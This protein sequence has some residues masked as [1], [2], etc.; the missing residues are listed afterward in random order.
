MT[1][2]LPSDFDAE[3][4]RATYLDVALSGL[5]AEEHYRRFGRRLGRR[6]NGGPTEHAFG[7]QVSAA[8][9]DE[10][11]TSDIAPTAEVMAQQPFPII[12]R[13]AGFEMP[14]PST[15]PVRTPSAGSERERFSF[16]M[17]LDAA[18]LACERQ[19][20][21][22]KPLLAYGRTFGLN[23]DKGSLD[24][25]RSHWCGAAAFQKG[26]TRIENAWHVGHSTLRLRLAGGTD[27]Q[28]DHQLT[29]RAY[30]AD[31]ESPD[32]LVM[33]GA[34]IELP[35]PGPIFHDAISMFGQDGFFASQL[36]RSVDAGWVGRVVL[37]IRRRAKPIE[38]IIGREVNERNA[39]FAR[40]PSYGPWPS[41]VDCERQVLF[42][43]GLVDLRVSGRGNNDV[44]T[45]DLDR[46]RDAFRRSGEVQFRPS[47]RD[48]FKIS[49][50]RTLAEGSHDLTLTAGD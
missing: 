21:I 50:G 22:I 6:V 44:G 9:E 13:P 8:T 30:Q 38:Y 25:D 32:E 46:R 3:W 5:G 23:V 20:Q 1:G 10:A 17:L 26:E 7:T 47:K 33:L 11:A 19:D 12:D 35:S 49:G 42:G 39:K 31:P 41:L 14:D 24:T 37:H 15:G 45:G 34:G 2:R 4:Y 29:L 48:N 16:A 18:L 40:R 36:G 43:L 27:V 28:S